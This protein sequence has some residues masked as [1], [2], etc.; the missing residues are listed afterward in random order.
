MQRLSDFV[1]GA[2][3]TA[4]EELN[5]AKSIRK[6]NHENTRLNAKELFSTS[7]AKKAT[8]EDEQTVNKLAP[9]IN[10]IAKIGI[11]GKE[12]VKETPKIGG[13]SLVNMTPSPMPGRSLGDE[14]PAMIWGEIESTPF[15][16][17]PGM[18]P[19][20]GRYFDSFSINLR[21]MRENYNINI[22]PDNHVISI[23]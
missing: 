18:T 13:Y 3:L 8:Q 22:K 5:Q 7:L 1:I 2:A 4:E 14:S 21:R 11:D 19:Y 15:R 6:I 20:T 12:S 10:R 16:L 23:N 17:D 9:Q